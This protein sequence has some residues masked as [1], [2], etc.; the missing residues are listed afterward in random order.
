MPTILLFKNNCS[1][2]MEVCWNGG[3]PSKVWVHLYICEWTP[4]Q[5]WGS[6]ARWL[7]WTAN[8]TLRN[9]TLCEEL[10]PILHS[11][12]MWNL[13]TVNFENFWGVKLVLKFYTFMGFN[14]WRT[15]AMWRIGTKFSQMWRI[16]TKSS[17][18]WRI[19]TKSSHQ[20]KIW[21]KFI[22]CTCKNWYQDSHVW[23]FGTKSSHM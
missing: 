1:S 17:H 22:T 10:V 18:M 15:S 2:H 5:N 16:G 9:F 4:I 21:Y 7:C 6:P 3:G 8:F 11:C 20:W 19:G 14:V 13:R 23:R 12:Q